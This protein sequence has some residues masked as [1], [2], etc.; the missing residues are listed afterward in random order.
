MGHM[1]PQ[2]SLVPYYFHYFP[3]SSREQ[4]YSRYHLLQGLGQGPILK[5]KK[6]KKGGAL[7]V[8]QE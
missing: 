6:K 5:K 3:F 4:R 8:L 7:E 1:G 2:R